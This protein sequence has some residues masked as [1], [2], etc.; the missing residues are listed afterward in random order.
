MT[1][2]TDNAS[3]EVPVLDVAGLNLNDP[4]APPSA[5]FINSLKD[6]LSTVG[7]L[8]L[9]GFDANELEGYLTRAQKWYYA[10]WGGAILNGLIWKTTV[11]FLE[12]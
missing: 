12:I 1:E 11:F 7:F 10:R 6:A 3:D 5:E 4:D 8:Y 9:G 2:T